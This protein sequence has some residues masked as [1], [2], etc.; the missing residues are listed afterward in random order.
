VTSLDVLALSTVNESRIFGVETM[1]PAR[2][3]VDVGVVLGDELPTN[4]GR[5]DLGRGGGG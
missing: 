4:L 1:Q 3:L 5:N 2:L